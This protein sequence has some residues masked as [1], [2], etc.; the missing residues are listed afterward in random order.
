[1]NLDHQFTT[2]NPNREISKM[3]FMGHRGSLF[4]FWLLFFFSQKKSMGAE[5]G[6]KSTVFDW[7]SDK[8]QGIILSCTILLSTRHKSGS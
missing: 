3:I 2:K 4:C 7:Q 5:I 8:M 6:V 1:M